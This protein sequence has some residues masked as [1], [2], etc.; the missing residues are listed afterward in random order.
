MVAW[1]EMA[2]VMGALVAAGTAATGTYADPVQG[3]GSS[4]APSAHPFRAGRSR[5]CG[6]PQTGAGIYVMQTVDVA[7]TARA[8]ALYVP[9]SYDPAR[10]YPLVFRW[11]GSGGNALSGGLEIES[12]SQEDALIA[13]PTG[14]R[15]TWDLTPTG[16]DVQLFDVLLADLEG[17]YC[18]DRARVFSYGFSM[19]AALTNLLGCVRGDVLRAVAPVAGDVPRLRACRG[20]VAAFVTH[21]QQDDAVPLARGRRERDAYLARAGC[22]T[23]HFDPVSPAPCVRYRGCRPD[24]PV[25]WCELPSPHNPLGAF[26]GPGAWDFFRSLR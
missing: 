2:V 10:A 8:Y 11:H 15:G 14:Q 23:A 9:R 6:Q 22:D 19:G 5:G 25:V 24:T 26:T 17:R 7:G 16:S 12:A 4:K 20:R 18:V 21:G 3:P 13:S 1:L